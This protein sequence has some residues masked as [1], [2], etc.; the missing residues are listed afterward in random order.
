MKE[1]VNGVHDNLRAVAK[2]AQRLEVNREFRSA[3]V[4]KIA[5]GTV[6]VFCGVVVQIALTKRRRIA[7]V[8]KLVGRAQLK[9]DRMLGTLMNK[10]RRA[11][12]S[13]LVAH[14]FS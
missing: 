1:R 4:A 14:L 10:T 13:R 8:E 12:T 9:R 11:R 6:N 7:L 3:M 5:K 2:L